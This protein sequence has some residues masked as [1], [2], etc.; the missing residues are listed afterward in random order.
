LH[1]TVVLSGNSLEKNKVSRTVQSVSQ[2]EGIAGRERL[3]SV[4]NYKVESIEGDLELEKKMLADINRDGIVDDFDVFLL[5][6][7]INSLFNR[8]LNDD[9][10]IDYNDVSVVQRIIETLSLISTSDFSSGVLSVAAGAD[11]DGDGKVSE[12]EAE[13]FRQVVNAFVDV[14]FDGE[15]NME[16]INAISPLLAGGDGRSGAMGLVSGAAGID[17]QWTQK[18]LVVTLKTREDSRI[19]FF[20]FGGMFLENPAELPEGDFVNPEAWVRARYSYIDRLVEEI[21]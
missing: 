13:Q 3:V 6:D 15:V 19:K 17:P 5:T 7:S 4:T 2:Y 9:G 12:A 16:D 8:D 14:N 21:E 18:G 11:L 1:Q 20:D 10:K